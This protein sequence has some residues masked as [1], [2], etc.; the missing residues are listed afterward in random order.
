MIRSNMQFK[1]YPDNK[2]SKEYSSLN[3]ST[4]IQFSNE[5]K[6]VDI[7]KLLNRIKINQRNEK[8]EKLIFFVGGILLVVFAVVFILI[9]N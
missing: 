4:K 8:K 9:N 1:F 5:K 2:T 3:Q 7:N 6:N